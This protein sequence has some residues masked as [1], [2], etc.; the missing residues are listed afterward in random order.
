[1]IT[2]NR[3]NGSVGRVSVDF[4]A[5]SLDDPLYLET[6][7]IFFDDGQTST[8]FVLFWSFYPL[9]PSQAHPFA[10]I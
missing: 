6:G 3:M 5:T 10:S 4:T 2:I 9:P 1:M 8:N 7:R